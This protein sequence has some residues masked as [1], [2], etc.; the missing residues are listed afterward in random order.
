M[1]TQLP[2]T[3]RE[4][5]INIL[6]SSVH[7]VGFI[8]KN[9]MYMYLYVQNV[10]F[11]KWITSHRKGINNFKFFY[12]CSSVGN[13]TWK[14]RL[15]KLNTLGSVLC[16]STNYVGY[17]MTVYWRR[18]LASL[19]FSTTRRNTMKHVLFYFSPQSAFSSYT[20]SLTS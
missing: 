18:A 9:I 3:R 13:L 10:G 19:T 16:W 6:R 15:L 12:T 5:E 7:L 20:S 2:E 17:F 14:A 8:W 1:D 11:R 4:V